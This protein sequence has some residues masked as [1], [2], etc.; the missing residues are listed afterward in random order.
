MNIADEQR[1]SSAPG[2]GQTLQR[3]RHA[4]NANHLGVQDSVE[5]GR[6][7]DGKKEGCDLGAAVKAGGV[8]NQQAKGKVDNPS[9]ACRDDEKVEEAQPNRRDL[10][11]ESDEPIGEAKS[12]QSRSHKQERQADQRDFGCGCSRRSQQPERNQREIEKPVRKTENS[13]DNQNAQNRP[14]FQSGP[15]SSILA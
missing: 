5:C 13:L 14:R 8:S 12:Q 10:I 6:Q 9:R 7:G 2:I 4:A 11:E 3:D 1:G 15:P